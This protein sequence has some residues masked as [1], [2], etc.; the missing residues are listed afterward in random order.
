M[1]RYSARAL[2]DE[3][4]ST[5]LP[6]AG[7][8]KRKC[9]DEEERPDHGGCRCG[10]GNCCRRRNRDRGEPGSKRCD[11]RLLSEEQR[12]TAR[13]RERLRGVPRVRAPDRLERGRPR[14]RPRPR[15]DERRRRPRRSRRARRDR[16][17]RRTARCRRPRWNRR[18]GRTRRDRRRCRTAR[19][20]RP[21]RRQ[22][23]EHR[24]ARGRQL[25]DW[26]REL[27]GGE[28]DDLR[29]QRGEG[30]QGRQ[31]RSRAERGR[32]ASVGQVRRGVRSTPRPEL[33][34]GDPGV[35]APNGRLPGLLQ[36]GRLDLRL[37]DDRGP[38]RACQRRPVRSLPRQRLRRH[39]L[40]DRAARRDLLRAGQPSY[41]RRRS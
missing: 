36:P 2:A 30:R 37:L 32:D 33:E 6:T 15:R 1:D 22:R 39:V 26:R 35:E 5:V 12:A 4:T 19:R 3:L 14:R 27:H 16:R 41:V 23:H 7:S 40:H 11:P 13:R 25:R 18:G 29:L 8:P 17:R 10:R 31:R 34:R 21:R 38:W 28:R 9:T 20:R 24:R